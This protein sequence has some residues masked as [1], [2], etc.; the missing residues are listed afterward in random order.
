MEEC[1]HLNDNSMEIKKF[2]E[3]D[4]AS[5]ETRYRTA[6]V[7]FAGRIQKRGIRKEDKS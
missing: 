4:L 6:F 5:M 1:E 7:N 2:T 3:A